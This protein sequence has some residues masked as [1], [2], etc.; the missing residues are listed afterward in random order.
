MHRKFPC[1]AQKFPCE[2]QKFPCVAQTLECDAQ[3]FRVMR[4]NVSVMRKKFQCNVQKLEC[5][6]QKFRVQEGGEC[7]WCPAIARACFV[8]KYIMPETGH[9][10]AA[11]PKYWYPGGVEG[12]GGRGGLTELNSQEQTLPKHTGTRQQSSTDSKSQDKNHRKKC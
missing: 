3:K 5:D 12:G 7:N 10:Q 1:D 6:A 9:H 2:T 4:R 11:R 8:W